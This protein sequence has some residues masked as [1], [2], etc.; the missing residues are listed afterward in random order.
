MLKRKLGHEIQDF[1]TT[2]RV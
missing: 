1:W 2:R